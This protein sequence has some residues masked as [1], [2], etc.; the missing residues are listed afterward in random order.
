MKEVCIMLKCRDVTVRYLCSAAGYTL[1]ELLAVLVLIGLLGALAVPR[2]T[3]QPHWQL[4]AASRRM[5]G[6]LRLLRQEAVHAGELCRVEFYIY[7]DRYLLTLP[8]GPQRVDLP[9]GVSFDGTTTFSGTPPV[10][11]FNHLG[12]P[13]SGGTVI[14]KA[15]EDFRYIIVTPVTGRVRVSRSQPEHW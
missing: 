15:G 6:D 5:A 7:A 2:F 13:G 3:A 14:L 4:E 12:R 11:Q 9:A 10:L 1:I 8:D